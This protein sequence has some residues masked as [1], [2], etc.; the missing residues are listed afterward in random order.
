MS[1]P[2][3]YLVSGANRGIG[4]ALVATLAA[5]PDTVVFAGAR[6]PSSATELAKLASAHP[7]K[8]HV[9]ALASA[10]KATNTAA[11]ETIRKTT[12]KLD[13]VIANAA[14]GDE[15]EDALT[16]EKETMTK[17]FDVNVNGPLVLFQATYPLLKESKAP[18]FVTVS[19]P[20]GSITAGS[21][22]PGRS[23]AYGSSKAALNWVT[24][25]I[26]HDFENLVAF[27]ISPG[28][29]ETDMSNAAVE[30]DPWLKTLPRL[31]P[32]ESVDGMLKEIDQATRETHGGQFVDYTGLG[33][34][35]W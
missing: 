17:H 9:V 30:K 6:N 23:Y 16:I 11:A 27:P 18:K 14:I 34:W 25:K 1:Q 33:K 22:W 4:L 35:G 32:K 12:G 5:R 7:G 10:D 2:T 8:V 26:H 19:S 21:Q 20:V 15:N 31:T 24:R 13:V 29:V 28:F 3:V